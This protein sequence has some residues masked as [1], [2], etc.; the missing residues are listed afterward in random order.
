MGKNRNG[1]PDGAIDSLLRAYVSR[2][3]NRECSEFDADLANA[4]I[5]RNLIPATRSRY[6]KHLSECAACRKNVVALSRL[7]EPD[8]RPVISAR[9]DRQPAGSRVF[10][11]TSWAR[12]AMAAAAVIVLAISLPLLLTRNSNRLAQEVSQARPESQAAD[13]TQAVNSPEKSLAANIKQPLVSSIESQKPSEKRP[14]DAV[15]ANGAAQ[16]QQPAA[17]DR[18]AS[19]SKLEAKTEPKPAEQVSGAAGSQPAAEVAAGKAQQEKRTDQDASLSARQQQPSKDAAA[20]D[21]KAN[22]NEQD[23]ESARAK[24]QVAESVATPPPPSA[25]GAKSGKMK[26]SSAMRALRDSASA[27]AVRPTERRLGNKKFSL[28]DDTWTDKDF[29]PDKDLPIV[30]VIRDSNVY[31]ELLAKQVGLKPYLGGFP[32]AERAIIVYKGTVYKLI[33]QQ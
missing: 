8:A 30:T 26:R 5:E 6:E 1:T 9:A 25:P 28:K 7:V 2:P 18:A 16:S 24:T 12:W 3:G 21:T 31:N 20:A 15:S 10:G 14:A 33:P 22:A 11:V 32:P 4:Y 23:K 19:S 13:S 27:E 29:D 17:G